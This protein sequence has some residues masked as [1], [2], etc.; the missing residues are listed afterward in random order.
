[1]AGLIAMRAK[2][3]C[4]VLQ[5][6]AVRKSSISESQVPPIDL[7]RYLERYVEDIQ[8]GFR[9]ENHTSAPTI[10]ERLELDDPAPAGK[11]PKLDGAILYIAWRANCTLTLAEFA[12]VAEYKYLNDLMTPKEE[13]EYESKQGISNL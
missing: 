8:V 10:S 3:R 11:T 13:A 1:M 12:A 5:T 7:L 6:Q 4:A 2:Q 9:Q